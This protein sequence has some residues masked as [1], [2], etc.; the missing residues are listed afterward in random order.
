MAR[1]VVLEHDHPFLHWDLM[2]EAG[3]VLRSWRLDQPPAPGLSIRAEAIGDHRKL[4]LDYEGPVS[5]GRGQVSR[6]DNGTC[7]IIEERADRLILQVD[8][9]R[10]RGQ[11]ILRQIDGTDWTFWLEPAD[12]SP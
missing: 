4:Y 7:E 12:Q 10:C 8:G 5:R 9:V 11:A 1:F 3:D 2:I 6:W